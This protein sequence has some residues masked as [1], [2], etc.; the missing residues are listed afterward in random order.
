[1]AF[2]IQQDHGINIS[3]ILMDTS[4]KVCEGHYTKMWFLGLHKQYKFSYL[5]HLQMHMTINT[6]VLVIYTISHKNGVN[7]ECHLQLSSMTL[8]VFITIMWAISNG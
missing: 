1:M 5:C 2:W 8:L 4:L 7:C 3:K 6:N